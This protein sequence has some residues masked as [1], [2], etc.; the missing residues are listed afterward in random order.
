MLEDV[1]EKVEEFPEIVKTGSVFWGIILMALGGILILAN[2]EVISYNTVFD[3]W[4]VVIIII[5]VKLL[6][7]YFS[8]GKSKVRG[9]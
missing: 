7:E 9:E 8:K 1:E 2:F 5:G 3:F 4:P 6:A